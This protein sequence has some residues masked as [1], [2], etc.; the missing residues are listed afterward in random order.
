MCSTRAIIM[1]HSS[2]GV[3]IGISFRI[4]ILTN[5]SAKIN[6]FLSFSNFLT[7]S[8]KIIKQL[9]RIEVANKMD[10]VFKAFDA[11]IIKEQSKINDKSDKILNFKN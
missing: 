11:K 7:S 1:D 3:N 5:N 2:C 6:T 10:N 9:L 4:K 8:S